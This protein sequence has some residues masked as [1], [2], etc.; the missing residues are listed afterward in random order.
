MTVDALSA[1]ASVRDLAFEKDGIRVHVS[2]VVLPT[3]YAVVAPAL[4]AGD[5][6]VDIIAIETPHRAR[7]AAL[8]SGRPPAMHRG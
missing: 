6:T 8:R 4:A 3:P 2:R 5:L 1:R 7:R